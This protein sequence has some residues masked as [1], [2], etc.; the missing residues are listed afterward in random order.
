MSNA[1]KVYVRML[2][3]CACAVPS[4]CTSYCERFLNR[5]ATINQSINQWHCVIINH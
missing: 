5:A 1:A 4:N 3:H 2:M